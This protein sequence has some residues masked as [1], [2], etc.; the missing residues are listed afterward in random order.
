MLIFVWL[1]L[2]TSTA[3]EL[4]DSVSMLTRRQYGGFRTKWSDALH[5]SVPQF[6]FDR[7]VQWDPFSGAKD[8]KSDQEFKLQ[9]SFADDQFLTSWITLTDGRGHYLNFIKIIFLYSGNIVTGIRWE[10]QYHAQFH[11]G[12]RPEHIYIRYAWDHVHETDVAA[13]LNLLVV[14]SAL[15]A[16]A[17]VFLVITGQDT[18]RTMQAAKW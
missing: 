1:L 15:I 5:G 7:T 9:C 8:Y 4:G 14:F 11:D 16:Y 3:Y 13:G 10:P 18:L 17:A 6:G 12:S 2:H